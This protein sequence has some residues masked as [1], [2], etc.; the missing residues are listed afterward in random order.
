MSSTVTTAAVAA[1]A[2]SSDTPELARLVA[3]RVRALISAVRLLREPTAGTR[4]PCR[5]ASAAGR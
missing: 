3:L 2:G 4:S 5:D 1:V